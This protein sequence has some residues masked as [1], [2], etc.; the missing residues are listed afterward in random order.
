MVKKKKFKLNGL[1]VYTDGTACCIAGFSL[2]GDRRVRYEFLINRCLFTGQFKQIIEQIFKECDVKSFFFY[3][4]RPTRDI[5][6]EAIAQLIPFRFERF[7]CGKNWDVNMF[8]LKNCVALKSVSI[9]VSPICDTGTYSCEELF[10]LPAVSSKL[11][12]FIQVS[13]FQ[14][15]G[16][17][18]M[19]C[20]NVWNAEVMHPTITT[21]LETSTPVG[22][23]IE[24]SWISG[25]KN[26]DL[27]VDK[28]KN[29]IM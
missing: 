25:A 7:V 9:D 17:E 18:H 24:L 3:N 19:E 13:Q 15:L 6:E 14:I 5:S 20:L 27:F 22:K 26:L 21:W 10:Q 28:F 1:H 11:N 2:V 8:V 29:R 12:N 4:V 16:A 23:S